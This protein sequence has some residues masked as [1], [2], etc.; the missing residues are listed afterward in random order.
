MDFPSLRLH[1][2]ELQ[3]SLKDCTLDTSLG[4][5]RLTLGGRFGLGAAF[6]PDW[7][8]AVSGTQCLP[9]LA[10]LGAQEKYACLLCS[11]GSR[12]VSWFAHAQLE[13]GAVLVPV[14]LDTRLGCLFLC[15]CVK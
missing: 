2:P 9:P 13:S 5:Q 8:D 15:V 11:A 4:L 6:T 12:V 1:G 10:S 7:R 3:T 14:L